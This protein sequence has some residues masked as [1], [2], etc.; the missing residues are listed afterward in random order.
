MS[1]SLYLTDKQTGEVLTT[2]T[3]HI[4]QGGN[5]CP[6]GTDEMWLNITYNYSPLY[7]RVI[8]PDG[9]HTLEG[10]TGEESLD[11]LYDA[12]DKLGDDVVDNYWEPTEG[13]AKAA[14]KNLIYLAERGPEGIWK[15][16]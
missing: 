4:L 1:Y 9:L 7:K 13:N 15:I 8:G 14:L 5:Y 11:I 10:M 16:D 6:Y 3:R 2:S 12:V